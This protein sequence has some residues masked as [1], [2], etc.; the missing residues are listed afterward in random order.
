MTRVSDIVKYQFAKFGERR[1]G[2]IASGNADHVQKEPPAVRDGLCCLVM[3]VGF[4]RRHESC[5]LS[6]RLGHGTSLF[7]GSD[8][9][10]HNPGDQLDR[11]P[12]TIG[13]CRFL[14]LVQSANLSKGPL[15]RCKR[16][17]TT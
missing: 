5:N 10:R 9:R 8:R 6:S 12:M 2:M 11:G 7:L 4:Q 16:I 13:T 17:G 15:G 14:C 3:R 1:P